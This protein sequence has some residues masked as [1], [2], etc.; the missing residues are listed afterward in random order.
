MPVQLETY[1]KQNVFPH[2]YRVYKYIQECAIVNT[3]KIISYDPE[4]Y[5]LTMEKI[6]GMNLSDMFGE[7]A[8]DIDSD[9]FEEVR[10]II[11]TLKNNNIEYPDIT[12]YNF[13]RSDSD[14]KL[15]IIDFEHAYVT[16]P[17]I[18]RFIK[19]ENAWNP[20]YI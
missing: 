19:G 8:S 9:L 10:W 17:F 6:Q 1:I 14:G 13:I 12:G 18:D 15:Y 3:P 20:E 11:R 7:K 5:I 4:R 2:E 16:D